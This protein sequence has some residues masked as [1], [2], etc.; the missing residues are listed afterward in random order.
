MD[1]AVKAELE[2]LHDEDSRQNHRLDKL[3][4]STEQ[5]ATIA[6]S[7]QK[8]ALSIEAMQKTMEAHSLKLE[9]IESRPAKAWTSMQRTIFNTLIGAA[10]GG[11]AVVLGNLF[12]M[13]IK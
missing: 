6:L 2:R 12:M 5:L 13:G 1:E 7:V 3:E 4:E 11:L 9:E 8:L 10:A